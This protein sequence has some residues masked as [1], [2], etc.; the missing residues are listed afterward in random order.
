MA[1]DNGKDCVVSD[2]NLNPDHISR[3]KAKFGDRAKIEVND[4]FLSVSLEECIQRDAKRPNPVGEKAVRETYNRWIKK[5]EKPK[6]I[7]WDVS[8]KT[9]VCFDVDGTLTNGPKD[10]SPYEWSKVGQ[11]E[12]NVSIRSLAQLHHFDGNNTIIIV[13]GRDAVCR[14]ET[15]KWLKDNNIPYH[16]L[17]MR[18]EN[19]NRPD[20]IVKEEI[21]DNFILPQYNIKLWI[22]DRLKVCRMVYR[23]GIPLL[24]V[25]DPDA[26]F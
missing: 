11:D 10:R 22:D 5:E 17:F 3:I 9:A 25:G 19:D 4:S 16:F 26:N 2:T 6:M 23:K 15:E 21:I 24:R 12:V 20:D 7:E 13:S 18:N 1:L 14:P 8:K